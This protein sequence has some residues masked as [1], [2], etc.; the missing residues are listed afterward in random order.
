M[1]HMLQNAESHSTMEIESLMAAQS[2]IWNEN[3]D[4]ERSIPMS[5]AAQ[6]Q[7]LSVIVD[8]YEEDEFSE[9]TKQIRERLF[10][11]Q[12]ELVCCTNRKNCPFLS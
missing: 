4:G 3:T 10:D 2:M 7:Q 9:D 12:R 11:A 8:E 6:Q 1:A 5:P